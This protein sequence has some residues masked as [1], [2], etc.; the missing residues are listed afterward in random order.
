MDKNTVRHLFTRN[1]SNNPKYIY[2]GIVDIE[3]VDGEKPVRFM[4][5]KLGF[6]KNFYTFWKKV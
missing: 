5:K 2:Q 1:N 3:A 4:L 6:Q